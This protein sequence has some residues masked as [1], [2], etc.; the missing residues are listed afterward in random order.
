MP[1]N[2]AKVALAVQS[3]LSTV[4]ATCPRYWEGRDRGL[5]GDACTA[6]RP[7]ASPLDGADYPEYAGPLNN[8]ASVWCFICGDNASCIVQR[9]NSLKKFGL[10]ADHRGLLRKMTPE[11][12]HADTPLL[13]QVGGQ[14]HTIESGTPK[15]K[16]SIF[17]IIEET[18]AEFRKRDVERGLI[19]PEE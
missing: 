10:C 12:D 16:K 6:R 11:Q 4:C 5:P 9:R 3:G 7:C 19:P 2:P 18:E 1:L 14:T 8:D 15:P 17:Q 13:I